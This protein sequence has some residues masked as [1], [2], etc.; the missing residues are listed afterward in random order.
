MDN[1]VLGPN[2]KIKISVY[3]EDGLTGEYVIS[4]DGKVSLPLVGNVNAAGKTIKQ[5]QDQLCFLPGRR[6]P[7][8]SQN[9]GGSCI[10]AAIFILGEVKIP[11][12]IPA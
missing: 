12:N 11:D 6:L 2:D 10:R 1:Y 5:F 3:G 7:K 9:R 8:G 4:S